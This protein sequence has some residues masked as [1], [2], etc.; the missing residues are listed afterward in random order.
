MVA[1]VFTD[2][3]IDYCITSSKKYSSYIQDDNKFNDIL[4]Q[5]TKEGEMGQPWKRFLTAT[6]KILQGQ[7]NLVF[8]SGHNVPT[9]FQNLQKEV[10]NLQGA[11]HSPNMLFTMVHGQ[12]SVLKPDNTP[13]LWVWTL[14]T[15][16]S[17]KPMVSMNTSDH[18]ICCIV[19]NVYNCYRI[20]TDTILII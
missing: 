8:C 7:I 12:V 15:F 10:L 9:L 13:A 2:W 20:E 3:W 11:W 17:I 16:T 1:Y 14:A 19:S 6:R 18:L 5:D 4:N